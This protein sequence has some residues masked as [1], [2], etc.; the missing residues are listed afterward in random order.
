MAADAD[1]AA[2]SPSAPMVRI[3]PPQDVTDAVA[4]LEQACKAWLPAEVT[5]DNK[6]PTTREATA[7]KA[8]EPDALV[9]MGEDYSFLST[10]LLVLLLAFFASVV[11]RIYRGLMRSKE[12]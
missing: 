8:L 10:P 9:V 11:Y 12:T 7:C 4:V 5:A 6:S 1:T 3:N 2:P